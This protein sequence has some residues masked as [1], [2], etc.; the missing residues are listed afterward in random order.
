[1]LLYIP[2]L[3]APNPPPNENPPAGLG[4][5]SF[6]SSIDIYIYIYII[7]RIVRLLLYI[8]GLLAPNPPP[9]E[10]PPAGLG[11]SS[12]FSSTLKQC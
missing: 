1:M 11:A 12:F 8:P 2:G 3:F 7:Y 5:S 4:T 10:K 9:N 6:F